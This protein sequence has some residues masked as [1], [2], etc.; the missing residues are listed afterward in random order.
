VA[1]AVS[2]CILGP[3]CR[4]SVDSHIRLATVHRVAPVDMP[5]LLISS[6]YVVNFVV[7]FIVCNKFLLCPFCH[8]IFALTDLLIVILSEHI[9]GV[10]FFLKNISIWTIN[11][12]RN[13]VFIP[14]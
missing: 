13:C 9:L 10:V 2:F 4:A 14:C 8:V 11:D 3:L 1:S 5:D 6:W 7:K 12:L